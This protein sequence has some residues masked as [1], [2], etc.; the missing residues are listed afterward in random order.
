ME[1]FITQMVDMK[2]AI[3]DALQRLLDLKMDIAS[4]INRVSSAEQ[5]VLL[6]LRYLCCKTWEDIAYEMNYNVRSV[7]KVH[8]SALKA[9][10]TMLAK[11]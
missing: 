2:D 7:Y 10:D 9:V 3:N 5:R 8:G 6:E 4:T 1:N 11:K